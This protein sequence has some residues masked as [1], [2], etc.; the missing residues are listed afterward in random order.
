MTDTPTTTLTTEDDYV[1]RAVRIARRNA[2]A[3]EAGVLTEDMRRHGHTGRTALQFHI[4]TMCAHVTIAL[5]MNELRHADPARARHVAERLAEFEATG[6]S[7]GEL[8][9]EWGDALADNRSAPA[10]AWV[11]GRPGGC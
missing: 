4:A 9:Y 3:L 5:L 1:L 2:D 8:L 11:L 6:D 10:P 7:Y